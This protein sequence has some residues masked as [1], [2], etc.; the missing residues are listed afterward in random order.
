MSD[1]H[2][3]TLVTAAQAVRD[4][5]VS[6]L[7]LTLSALARAESLQPKFNAFVRIDAEE[8]LAAARACDADLAKGKLKRICGGMTK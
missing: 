1:L 3:M 4:K 8:A 2:E 6:S 5:K 7:E